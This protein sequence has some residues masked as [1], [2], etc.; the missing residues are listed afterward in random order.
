MP[1]HPEAEWM[2][3]VVLDAIVIDMD[4]KLPLERYNDHNLVV[5]GWWHEIYDKQLDEYQ[6]RSVPDTQ[7][8]V[9]HEPHRGMDHHGATDPRL[10]K[11]G[12]DAKFID[13]RQANFKFRRSIGSDL[14]SNNT[15]RRM[16]NQDLRGR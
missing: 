7:L 12:A 14:S 6:H 4:F 5:H 2:W 1:A 10:R 8:P 11:M 13:Q 15:A 9:V 16:G 3:W